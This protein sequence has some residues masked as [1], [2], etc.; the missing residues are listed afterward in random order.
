MTNRKETKQRVTRIVKKNT[1][2]PTVTLQ[3][4]L[5]IEYTT[6]FLS[7]PHPASI[8]GGNHFLD[9]IVRA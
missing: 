4:T 3:A 9:E 2:L 6:S 7:F 1:S 5:A 8:S